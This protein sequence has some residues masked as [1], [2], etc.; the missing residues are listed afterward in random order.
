MQTTD[1]SS[2]QVLRLHAT[3]VALSSSAAVVLRGPSGAGK[4][5]LALRFLSGQSQFPGIAPERY[6]IADDQTCLT[7]NGGHL[8][9]SAPP[10]FSGLIE[11]RGLGIATVPSLA[12][13]VIELVVDL[14]PPS[15]VERYPLVP[16]TVCWLGLDVPLRRLAAFDAAAPLKLALWLAGL[17]ERARITD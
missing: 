4:S 17:I 1:T 6:L 9:A 15:S 3:T 8:L 16:E 2:A 5:D 7:R 11:A 14:V 13:A 12:S 10:G